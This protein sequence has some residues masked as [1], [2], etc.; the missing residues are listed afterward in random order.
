MRLLYSSWIRQNP[1]LSHPAANGLLCMLLVG[2]LLPLLK[3]Y[4]EEPPL[5]NRRASE[6]APSSKG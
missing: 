2:M 6:L 3:G 1:G 4:K 5:W